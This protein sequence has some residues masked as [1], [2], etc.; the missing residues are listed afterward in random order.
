[1]E[2]ARIL[3]FGD[4]TPS[5]YLWSA[6]VFCVTLYSLI[7]LWNTYHTVTSSHQRLTAAVSAQHQAQSDLARAQTDLANSANP[8]FIELEARRELGMIRPGETPYAV[9]NPPE[10]RAVPIEEPSAA[11]EEQPKSLIDQLREW[12]P[13]G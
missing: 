5:D 4:G 6:V 13:F 3:L 7:G 8:T 9:G 11:P 12:L 10:V 2:R 1:M